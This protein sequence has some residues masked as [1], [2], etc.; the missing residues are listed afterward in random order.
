MQA[1]AIALCTRVGRTLSV[2]SGRSIQDASFFGEIDLHPLFGRLRFSSYGRMIAF[3]PDHDIPDEIVAM[4]S[5]LAQE[6]GYILIPTSL[7]ETTY[8]GHIQSDSIDTWW[9]RYF[10]YL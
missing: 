5:D 3:T 6:R 8:S 7:L 10:D 9:I 1:F 2:N 4:V